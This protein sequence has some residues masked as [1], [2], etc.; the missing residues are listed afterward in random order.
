MVEATKGNREQHS[1]ISWHP[2]KEDK[3]FHTNILPSRMCI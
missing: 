1:H 2:G 3:P